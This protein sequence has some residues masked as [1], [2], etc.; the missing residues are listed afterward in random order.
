MRSYFDIYTTPNSRPVFFFHDIK[1]LKLV[2]NM[3][4]IRCFAYFSRLNY[5]F[6]KDLAPLH[7]AIEMF[8][9]PLSFKC[10]HKCLNLNDL[11][12]NSWNYD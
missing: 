11:K 3:L 5:E 12:K 4:L 8:E 10:M 1:D 2:I 6:I 9:I 7:C